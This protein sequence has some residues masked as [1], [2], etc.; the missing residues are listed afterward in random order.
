MT[1]RRDLSSPCR[2]RWGDGS[3]EP[4]DAIDFSQEKGGGGCEPEKGAEPSSLFKDVSEVYGQ[5]WKRSC[6][7]DLLTTASFRT[8]VGYENVFIWKAVQW[9]G[10]FWVQEVC[11]RIFKT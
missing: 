9:G 7:R 3:V 8:R 1:V 11:A 6:A 5:P 10:S 4:V 2:V